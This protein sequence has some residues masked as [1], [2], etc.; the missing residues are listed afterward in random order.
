[1]PESYKRALYAELGLYCGRRCLTYGGS[2]SK[3]IQSNKKL[4]MG[5]QLC[6][7]RCFSKFHN[8]KSVVD[9]EVAKAG[10]KVEP[11]HKYVVHQTVPFPN[12]Y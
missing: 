8:V 7:N 12:I 5:E 2:D 10:I 6:F 3:N 11:H 9:E 4:S 1:M